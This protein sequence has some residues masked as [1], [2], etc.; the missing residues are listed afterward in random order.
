MRKPF[1]TSPEFE[2]VVRGEPGTDLARVALEIAA[3][4]HPGLDVDAQMARIGAIADRVRERCRE[5]NASIRTLG[6]IDWVLF[7]EEGFTG[8]VDNYYEAPNSLLNEVLDRKTG[9]PI[10]LSILYR[11]VAARVGVDLSPVNLPAHFL[12][13]LDEGGPPTFVDPFHGGEHLDRAGCERRIAGLI[14]RG[15]PI[16]DDRFEPCTDAAVVARLLRNL[17]TIHLSEDDVP[18]ALLVQRRLAAVADEPDE[19]RDLGMLCLKV[20][21]AGEAIDPLVAY[22]K[23]RPA[24]DDVE[25]VRA[26]LSGARSVVARWN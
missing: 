5:G 19:L 21:E 25:T 17:K 26:L 8:N 16:P 7:V 18:S 22:L 1:P 12:L 15:D 20:D 3:D 23:A 9:I 13:R 4:F 11:A 24:A 10:T 2:R 14:G 6:Q